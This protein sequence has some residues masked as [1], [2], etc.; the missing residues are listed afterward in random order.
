[1]V[2]DIQSRPFVGQNGIDYVVICWNSSSIKHMPFQT[3]YYVSI[4]LARE[5][6]FGWNVI[7]QISTVLF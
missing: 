3:G 5:Y 4:S 1:M 7:D 2:E 6:C